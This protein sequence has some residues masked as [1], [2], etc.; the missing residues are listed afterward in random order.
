[1][2]RSSDA[3]AS[4]DRVAD[5]PLGLF[6][7][8]TTVTGDPEVFGKVYVGF[9]GNSFAVGAPADATSSPLP[10][11]VPGRGFITHEY[12]FN[13]TRTRL[14]TVP[15]DT[16]APDQT[17]YLTALES[18]VN[19]GL[20]NFG[21]RLRGYL[22]P[23]TSA[24]YTFWLASDN[25]GE[26]RLSTDASPTNAV[27]IASVNGFTAHRQWTKY[28]TQRSAPI[29]LVAGKR[30]YIE[31][32]A[33]ENTGGDHL[34][35]AWRTDSAT[36]GPGDIVPGS[37]LSPWGSPAP[38]DAVFHFETP[39][40]TQGWQAV[41]THVTALAS[42]ATPAYA[43]VGSLR[44]DFTKTGTSFDGP[45]VRVSNV[46]AAAGRT[47]TFR[48]R[49]PN[50]SGSAELLVFTQYGGNWT[51]RS[52]AINPTLDAWNTLT[53]DVPVTNNVQSLGVW[54]RLAFPQTGTLYLD[55]VNY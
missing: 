52:Q 38:D 21:Q 14:E 34:S 6:D 13:Q 48:A 19:I 44:V 32:R 22:T 23:T 9:A 25:H 35:V 42:G 49:V 18:P 41:N 46:H 45:Q 30:Y 37:V 26:L 39:G 10:A 27:V 43:G 12:W 50:L 5:Y 53:L 15:F 16:A 54:L 28:A 4:W 47:V 40:D 8:V 1:V 31:A 2:W 36:P 20:D 24:I 7:T 55:A 29:A 3:G 51:W 11:P 33:K 17:G